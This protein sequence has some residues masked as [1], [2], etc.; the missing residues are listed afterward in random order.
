MRADISVALLLGNLP[1]GDPEAL[2][3]VIREAGYL[4]DYPFLE[5][6]PKEA[7]HSV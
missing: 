7:N 2:P 4:E 1:D 3:R 5:T 6:L